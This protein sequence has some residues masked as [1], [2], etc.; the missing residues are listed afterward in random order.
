M[1]KNKFQIDGFT[2]LSDYRDFTIFRNQKVKA[3]SFL[4]PIRSKMGL[5]MNPGDYC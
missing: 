2:Q 3:E 1:S 5:E 4:L